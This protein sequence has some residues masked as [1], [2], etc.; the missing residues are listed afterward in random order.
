MVKDALKKTLFSGEVGLE[1]TVRDEG[2]DAYDEWR[3]NFIRDRLYVLSYLGFIANPAFIALDY[4]QH[5]E[6][7]FSLFIIRVVLQLGL[8]CGFVLFKYGP[9]AIPPN[10]GTC[11]PNRATPCGPPSAKWARCFS[12]G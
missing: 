4:L 9:K 10:S 8:L 5:R 12:P 7:L 3:R 1:D 2:A 6:N 11:S